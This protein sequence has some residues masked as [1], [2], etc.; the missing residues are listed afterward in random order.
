MNN[1]YLL[2]GSNLGN[3]RKHLHDAIK[4]IE[5]ELGIISKISAI[6]Q[7]RAWGNTHQPDF[8]NQVVMVV[9][10]LSPLEILSKIL[11]IE[12]LLGR[13]RTNKWEARI[14]DIDLLFY[15][16]QCINE[17]NLI[18]PHPYLHERSFT[19]I[20]LLEIA[21]EFCHP[22]LNKT[23]QQLCETLPDNLEV[24]KLVECKI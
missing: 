17:T 5:S 3:S 10:S 12:A 21:A 7:T 18:V 9:S 24:C 4:Y 22:V 13:T 19:L 8:L 1:I 2:L 11:S 15:N 23:I 20:P 14:I 16:N 6:Y